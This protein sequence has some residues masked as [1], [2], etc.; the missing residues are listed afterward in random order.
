MPY[1]IFNKN[2]EDVAGTFYRM[3]E[4]ES[5][6]NNLNIEITDYKII[7]ESLENFNN[8]KFE[9]KFPI[10][11]NISNVINYENLNPLFTRKENLEKIVNNLKQ[12]INL[13]LENNQNHPLFDRWNSYYNQLNSLDLDTINYPLTVSLEQY[14]N[15]LG[16]PSY[17]ILQLP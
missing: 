17:S 1:F 13:F 11:Y 15:N 10:S 9:I 3:A 16:Q 6:L 4:N 7:Q 14:F 8:V 5:D 2:Q 12:Q